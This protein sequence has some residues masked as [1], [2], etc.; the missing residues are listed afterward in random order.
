MQEFVKDDSSLPL[1]KYFKLKQ[2]LVDYIEENRNKIKKGRD[3]KLPSEHQL[4]EKYKYSQTTVRRALD[5]LEEDGMIYRINGKGTFVKSSTDTTAVKAVPTKNLGLF[6]SANI[7]TTD[8]WFDEFTNSLR[9]A[10]LKYG[11]NFLIVSSWTWKRENL[12]AFLDSESVD[13]LIVHVPNRTEYQK[14][15]SDNFPCIFLDEPSGT[16]ENNWISIDYREEGRLAT[17]FL[18]KN[19]HKEIAVL[20]PDDENC[21]SSKNCFDA[22]Q[23][24]TKKHGIKNDSGLIVRKG[25]YDK[26]YELMEGLIEERESGKINFTAVCIM[27]SAIG[28]RAIKA[29]KAEKLRIPDDISVIVCNGTSHLDFMEP[30]IAYVK[31]PIDKITEAM[32][33]NLVFRIKGEKSEIKEKYLKP[34]LIRGESVKDIRGH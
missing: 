14:L 23:D 27:G 9:R 11:Y 2:L 4:I 15:L 32:V 34:E 17:E 16:K 3:F 22:I 1:P 25:W 33:R 31:E 6:I 30:R 7:D 24:V 10:I 12:K 26:G 18:V 13:G 19:G 5:I 29:I 21:V 20:C 28:F 8:P